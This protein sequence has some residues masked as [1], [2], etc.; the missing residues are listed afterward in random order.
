MDSHAMI[1]NKYN[2]L[3]N[4]AFIPISYLF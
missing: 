2:L 3:K 4:K 1:I